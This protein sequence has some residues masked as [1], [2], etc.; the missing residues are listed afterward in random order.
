MY[1]FLL[2]ARAFPLPF[3]TLPQWLLWGHLNVSRSPSEPPSS[4]VNFQ[5]SWPFPGPE[6]QPFNYKCHGKAV[7]GWGKKK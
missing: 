5:I 3:S 7:G 6:S 1:Y 4:A 2:L